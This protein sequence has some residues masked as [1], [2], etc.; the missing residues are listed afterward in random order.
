MVEMKWR[1]GQVEVMGLII[2][3]ILITLGMFFMLK[4]TI[5][6]DPETNLF[7]EK[8]LLA[9]G[10]IGAL[11]NT[12]VVC[13]GTIGGTPLSIKEDLI[14]DCAI[15]KGATNS[16]H[17][18]GGEH[19]CDFLRGVMKEQLEVTLGKWRVNYELHSILV[20]G[21][22]SEE[23][24]GVIKNEEEDGTEK[25]CPGERESSGSFPINVQQIGL[26]ENTLYIC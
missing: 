25:G 19:S 26:V 11:I 12:N 17:Q 14:D 7:I 22:I 4:F 24:F 6:E 2:I 21:G 1:C 15:Y 8:P 18:C 16:V 9:N 13:E 5:D 23:L 20:S 3:V 10:V